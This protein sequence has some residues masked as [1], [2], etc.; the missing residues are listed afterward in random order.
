MRIEDLENAL[1]GRDIV[2]ASAILNE[3]HQKW[4][5]ITPG[6]RE[7]IVSLE[8]IYLTMVSSQLRGR[9]K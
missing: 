4:E 2:D 1:A 3:M 6:D 9:E 8:S 7:K 5:T